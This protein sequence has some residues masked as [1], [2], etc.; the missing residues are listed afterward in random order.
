MIGHHVTPRFASYLPVHSNVA[1][2]KL[3]QTFDHK[4][5]MAIIKQLNSV[6]FDKQTATPTNRHY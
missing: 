5:F 1:F 3:V 6:N 4:N 2:F